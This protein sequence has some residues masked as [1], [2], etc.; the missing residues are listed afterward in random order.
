MKLD[1]MENIDHEIE[2][3]DHE[4]RSNVS[5]VKTPHLAEVNSID[6]S[7]NEKNE[8]KREIQFEEDIDLDLALVER[9]IS[10]I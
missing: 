9:K 7:N 6:I 4:K 2:F 8:V 1:D 10:R 3:E 5:T